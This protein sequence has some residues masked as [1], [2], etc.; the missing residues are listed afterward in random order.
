MAGMP[1]PGD[2]DDL[3]T[4]MAEKGIGKI[5]CLTHDKAPYTPQKGISFIKEKQLLDHFD[6]VPAGDLDKEAEIIM[7]LAKRGVESLKKG[8][9]LVAHC[10]GGTGRTGTTIGVILRLL[11]YGWEETEAALI[12]ANK[13]RGKFPGGWPESEWQRELV[14]NASA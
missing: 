9:S 11:G 4:A 2:N 5:L 13:L 3:W 14:K 12:G 10:K 1:L 8:E 7:D 6:D